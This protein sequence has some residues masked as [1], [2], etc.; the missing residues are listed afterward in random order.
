MADY[1]TRERTEDPT[2]KYDTVDGEPRAT[3]ELHHDSKESDDSASSH[4]EL[5]QEQGVSR[6]EALCESSL[7]RV[8]WF[9]G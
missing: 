2:K 3:Y 9:V 5:E 1:Q 7:R 4:V 6:I 8:S